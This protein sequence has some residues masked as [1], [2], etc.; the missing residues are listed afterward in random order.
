VLIAVDAVNNPREYMACRKLIPQ[1]P[2]IAPQRLA[3]TTIAM[4]DMV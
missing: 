3:D 2:R 4:H 1:R